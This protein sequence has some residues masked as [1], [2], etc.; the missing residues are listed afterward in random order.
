MPK[1]H[2]GT[3][4]VKKINNNVLLHVRVVLLASRHF[5]ASILQLEYFPS[6]HTK[7]QNIYIL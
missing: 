4:R 2:Y 1:V 6:A 7:I 5:S 3:E